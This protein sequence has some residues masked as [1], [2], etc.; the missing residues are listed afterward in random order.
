[1]F[2]CVCEFMGGSVHRAVLSLC[3]GVC[4]RADSVHGGM[5]GADDDRSSLLLLSAGSSLLSALDV[6][7]GLR[8]EDD[9]SEGRSNDSVHSET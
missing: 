2:V 8:G 4:V 9:N 5:G 3:V 6:L 7:D 1:M